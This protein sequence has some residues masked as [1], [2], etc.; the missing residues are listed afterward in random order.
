MNHPQPSPQQKRMDAIRNRVAL[1]ARDWGVHSDDGRLCLT[2]TSNEGTIVVA[3]IARDAPVGE[4]ELALSAP[5][6]LIWLLE[7]Y[8]ALAGRYRTLRAELRR[9]A[10]HQEQ[11]RPKDYAAE[12]A[13]K[14]AEPAFK[15]FLEECHG[16]T[17]PLSD[18]RVATKVRSILKISS[19]AE[20]N[21]DP[22]AA[23]RWKK[24]RDHYDAWR[25]R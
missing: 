11:Q 15:V 25:K 5:E 9:D 12:C 2:A 20:L 24:L 4:S 13:M 19:R 21:D 16:L 18:D 10:P 22:A 1:A 17:R 8:E 7:T 6:D 23:S 14:C 3:T